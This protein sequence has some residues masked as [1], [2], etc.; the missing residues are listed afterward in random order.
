[1]NAVRAGKQAKIAVG[2]HPGASKTYAPKSLSKTAKVD[3]VWDGTDKEK[4]IGKG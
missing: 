1:V 4:P 2:E 3:E